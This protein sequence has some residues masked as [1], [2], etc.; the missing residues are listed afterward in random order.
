M[1]PIQFKKATL[2]LNGFIET[3]PRAFKKPAPLPVN[4]NGKAASVPQSQPVAR[5]KSVSGRCPANVTPMSTT[6]TEK[7]H[8]QIVSLGP[9]AFANC[10]RVVQPVTEKHVRL[11]HTQAIE[12]VS[13]YA[14]MYLEDAKSVSGRPNTNACMQVPIQQVLEQL[15]TNSAE[16]GELQ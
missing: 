6:E 8:N 2:M 5:V 9:E 13:P 4:T 12:R 14:A 16:G 15:R 11:Q 3:N 10:R 7:V 1:D